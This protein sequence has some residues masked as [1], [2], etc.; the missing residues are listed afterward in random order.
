MRGVSAVVQ[1]AA[2]A[3][4]ELGWGF[5]M[6]RLTSK[7]VIYRNIDKDSILFRLSRIC[8]EFDSREFDPEDLSGRVLDEIHRLLDLATSYGFDRNLWRNYV[9]FLL[10]MTET[11][12][13]LVCE[14]TGAVEGSVN[15]FA[16][17]DFRVFY[18]LFHYDFSSLEEALHLNCFSLIADYRSVSKKEQFYNKNVSAR[19]RELSQAIE[20]AADASRM[21]GIMMDFYRRFGVGQF[22]MNKAFRIISNE[23]GAKMA[24]GLQT[25][26]FS[27]VPI[28]ATSDVTLDDLIGYEAQKKELTRNTEA[29]LAGRPANNVL[30]YGDAGTGKSTSIK[31]LLNHYYEDGLRIIEV[32]KH[33]F[34]Y[35]PEIISI[36]KSRNYRFIIYMDDLSFES[37]ETEFKYLKA[38]I[39]GDLEVKPDNVLIYATSNR[40]HLI[41]ETFADREEIQNND[42][43]KNDTMAE[44][45]SL[46][47]RFG[48]SIGYFTPKRDEYF[49]IIRE[50]AGKIPEIK[51]PDEELLRQADRWAIR[52]ADMSGRSA[53]QFINDLISRSI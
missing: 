50:L 44:R 43:H 42:V 26:A 33:D 31:A 34:R 23:T 29:F 11:P 46:A 30:L 37:A 35:L 21:H 14:K 8:R 24:A 48:I 18:E 53:H 38:V 16:A 20:H 27:I 5:G 13:T 7:L 28:A 47:A 36:I 19:V 2:A 6:Y 40:R 41:R 3:R 12:F 22:G 25:A 17:G 10:A 39:E 52:H 4:Q 9:A 1:E 45:L 15:A 51:L 49:Q 32:Y